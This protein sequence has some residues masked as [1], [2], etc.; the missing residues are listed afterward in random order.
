KTAI[1]NYVQKKEKSSPNKKG[2]DDYRRLFCSDNVPNIVA[3]FQQAVVDTLVEKTIKAAKDKKI[4]TVALAGGVSANSCLREALTKKANEEGLEVVI[5]P[6]YLC[7]DNAAMIGC[8]GYYKLL[9]GEISDNL[10][11]PIA[12]LK[13]N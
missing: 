13:I 2:D 7:T 8:A 6:I 11:A 10:L 12:N 5:P 3:S 4:K 1:V 9:R